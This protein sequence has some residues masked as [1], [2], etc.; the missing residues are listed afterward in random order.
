[1]SYTYDHPRPSVTVD[2]IL[3]KYSDNKLEILMI[4]RKNEPYANHW[5][6]PGGFLDLEESLEDAVKR[7]L[8]EETG[9]EINE[10]IQ[11]GAFGKPGRDPRGRVISITFFGL[12]RSEEVTIEASSDAAE[13]KWFNIHDKPSPLAF[14]HEEIIKEFNIFL[15]EKLKLSMVDHISFYSLSIDEVKEINMLLT[16]K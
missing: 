5:A 9:L 11:I 15:R 8:K 1:M 16:D 2:N 6:L 7:E 13:A 14:D 12:L 3:L 10:V 4:K